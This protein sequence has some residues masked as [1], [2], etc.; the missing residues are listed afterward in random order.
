LAKPA[1][2][3]PRKN[4]IAIAIIGLVGIMV[5]AGF[6]NWDKIFSPKNVIQSSY[7]GYAPTGDAQVELRYFS[8]ITGM[9]GLVRGM[10]AEM[11]ASSKVEI[12]TQFKDKP[13][14]A[15]ELLKALDE[16][17][18][19]QYDQILNIYIPIASKYF[20]VAELQ[21]LNKFYSTPAMRE[22][23]RKGPL[24]NKEYMS[25][26]MPLIAKSKDRIQVKVED[27]LAKYSE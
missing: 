3:S 11:L 16:E 10:Q 20:S 9:R 15:K 8:E 19:L 18:E 23:T 25:A 2:Q 26:A 17:M 24:M 5:T 4:E 22:M 13:E 7:T 1:S 12:E 6:S 21:D 27:I 14:M